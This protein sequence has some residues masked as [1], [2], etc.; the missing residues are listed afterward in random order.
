MEC[1]TPKRSGVG[2]FCSILLSIIKYFP[3]CHAF[4]CGG[5]YLPHPEDPFQ[6]QTSLAAR[7]DKS[8]DLEM[9]ERL[10]KRFQIARDGYHLMVIP[11]ECDMCQFI[12][13]N[14]R[15]PMHGNYKDNYT[16]LC[17]RRAI[18]DDFWS[19]ETS[20]VLENFRRLIR[21]YFDSTE[22]LS[23]RRPVPIIGTDKVRDRVGIGCVIQNMYSSQRKGKWQD[24][25]QWDSMRRTHT[26]YKNLWEA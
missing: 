23:I 19:Q 15:D 13:V 12:N 17:I 8:E 3:P 22:A 2:I 20:T 21:D 5:C 10:N 9:E 26:W 18:L 11:F 25:L 16:L 4:W 1:E 14:E 7:Y 24:Q 6:V